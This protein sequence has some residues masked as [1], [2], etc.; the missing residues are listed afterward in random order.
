[1]TAA[2]RAA[3]RWR[4]PCNEHLVDRCY[5][6]ANVICEL[7]SQCA[8]VRRVELGQDRPTLHLERAPVLHGITPHEIRRHETDPLPHIGRALYKN[9]LL[10]W[11][12]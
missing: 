12:L 4:L 5:D 3:D 2:L 1:M 11:P 8:I 9:C 10:E 7:D 6:V